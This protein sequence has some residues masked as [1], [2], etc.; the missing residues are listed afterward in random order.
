MNKTLYELTDIYKNIYDLIMSGEND[1]EVF[2]ALATIEVAIE[3]KA[4]NYGIII[5]ELNSEI[6]KHKKEEE[7]LKSKRQ[8]LENKVNYLKRN[9]EE[10]MITLDKKKFK[11][12]HFSF[13][14]QKNVPGLEILEEDKIPEKYQKI[15]IEFDKKAIKDD[16]KAGVI[17]EGVRLKQSES[18]RIK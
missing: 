4:E 6:E 17:I 3:E 2:E 12:D 9:L 8:T 1:E 16:L 13:N 11:T 10:T 15:K 14:I 5:L 7:R 18:I